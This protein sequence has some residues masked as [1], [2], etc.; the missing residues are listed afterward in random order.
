M[1]TIAREGKGKGFETEN[2]EV[3]IRT[4]TR[5]GEGKRH[6]E[7]ERGTDFKQLLRKS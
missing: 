3:L 4:Y 7:R 6:E 2:L 1:L 5:R